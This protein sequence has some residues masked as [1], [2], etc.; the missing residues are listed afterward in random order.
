LTIGNLEFDEKTFSD[1]NPCSVKNMEVLS[2]AAELLQV[3][4][5]ELVASLVFKRRVFSGSN[6]KI[7]KYLKS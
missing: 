6:V 7:A 2:K 5:E 3:N 1:A 4:K